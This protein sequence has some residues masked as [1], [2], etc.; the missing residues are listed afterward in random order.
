MMSFIEKLNLISN[1]VGKDAVSK[2]KI[3][4]T[5]FRLTKET[6]EIIQNTSLHFE[7]YTQI[8]LDSIELTE[9]FE[10]RDLYIRSR[11]SECCSDEG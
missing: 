8:F 7:E 5:G 2:G 9:D 3:L 10:K 1:Q 11:L 6:E 4:E